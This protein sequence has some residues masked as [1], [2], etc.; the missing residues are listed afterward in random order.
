MN[1]PKLDWYFQ[2]DY[3]IN[4]IYLKETQFLLIYV[5]ENV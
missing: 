4:L 3:N 2:I 5:T 1:F